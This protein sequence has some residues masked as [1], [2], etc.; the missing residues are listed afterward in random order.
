MKGVPLDEL[1]NTGVKELVTLGASLA[2]IRSPQNGGEP[3][4]VIPDKYRVHSLKNLLPPTRI[5]QDV[6]LL[7]HGS[8]A[9]YVNRFKTDETLIFAHLT[10]SGATFV[11]LLDYHGK[12]PDL[13]AAFV[14]HKATFGCVETV[15]WT[16]WN[17]ANGR[18]MDQVAFAT[19]LEEH[20]KLIVD[21]PGAEL[22]ELV[23]NLTGRNEARFNSGIRLQSGQWKLTYDEDV[24]LK[25]T[26]QTRGGDL[27]LPAMI[28]AGIAPFEGMAAYEV[29]ARLKFR[30][31]NR[32]VQFWYET[33][34]AH[35]IVRDSIVEITK[36][37][38]AKTGIIPL[39]GHTSE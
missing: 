5:E 21:P 30:I 17:A 3:F 15:E 6:V 2:D 7:E 23:Q 19:F 35:R 33:V 31:E 26:S 32:K 14:S 9:D 1:E 39:I 22:L 4:L 29:N 24:V 13:K 10:N 12:A 38:A 18:H 28:K 34:A 25:G 20:A 27:E 16:E 37:I 8:F 36:A 11:A